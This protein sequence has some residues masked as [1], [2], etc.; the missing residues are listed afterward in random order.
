[1]FVSRDTG[2]TWEDHIVDTV[3]VGEPCL[4]EGCG[5]DF[6]IGHDAISADDAGNLVV[7]L[8]RR[9]DRPGPAADL[10]SHVD[11]WRRDVERADRLSVAGENAT[12][13][14]SS[15]RDRETS[16]RGT[17]RRATAM[18]PTPG[19]SSTGARTTGVS[20]SAPVVIST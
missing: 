15:L 7:P 13:R 1:V 5:P 14:P 8:R 16:A 11:R 17:C 6:Y 12:S 10:R 2:A 20:R 9:H 3:D 19:T 4:A 18:T